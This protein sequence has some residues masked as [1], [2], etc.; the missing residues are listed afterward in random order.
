MAYRVANV[1]GKLPLTACVD[2]MVAF[3]IVVPRSNYCVFK[4]RNTGTI[5]ERES[6]ALCGRLLPKYFITTGWLQCGTLLIRCLHN[7]IP[8][9]LIPTPPWAFLP[10]RLIVFKW[11]TW[12]KGRDSHKCDAGRYFCSSDAAHCKLRIGFES[13]SPRLS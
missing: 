9:P 8:L 7:Y 13:S 1:G 5:R 10:G 11:S 4:L 2:Y 3:G 6:G 12:E